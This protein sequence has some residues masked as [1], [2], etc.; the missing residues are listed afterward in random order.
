MRL[1]IAVLDDYIGVSQT[2]AD[3]EPLKARA[4]VAVFGKPLSVP[5]EAARELAD[6]DII[7]TLRERMPIPASLIERLPRLKYIVVTGKRYD[8]VDVAAA[9][10]RGIMVSN[11]PVGGA[12]SGGVAELVWGL[13]LALARHIPSEDRSM[14]TEGGK[15]RQGP[16]W[17]EELS[18]S[19]VSAASVAGSPRSGGCSAC[20]FRPGA[21]T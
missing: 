20:R 2:V 16:R 3:W 11:T 18:A 17:E 15:I 4:N 21:R 10:A 12:G 13:I 1:N 5:E 19:S 6:F 8:T 9:A 7:C 14:R